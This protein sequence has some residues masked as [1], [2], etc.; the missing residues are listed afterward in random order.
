MRSRR[1]HDISPPHCMS[2]HLGDQCQFVNAKFSSTGLYYIEECLGPS[3]P[4]YT[5]RHASHREDTSTG[6]G[7]TSVLTTSSYLISSHLIS[8]STV[9][10]SGCRGVARNFPLV[11]QNNFI[12]FFTANQLFYR[13]CK[14]QQI[15]LVMADG[16]GVPT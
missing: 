4:Q 5:L 8:T 16:G 6:I 10:L 1:P 11:V 2:C 9:V 3:I 14:N 13:I 12:R 15:T 7:C